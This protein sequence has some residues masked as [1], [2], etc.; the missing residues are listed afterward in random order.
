AQAEVVAGAHRDAVADQVREA[1]DESDSR[2][3]RGALRSGEDRHG[4]D[5]A[6]ERAV[7]HVA[8]VM[9]EAAAGAA[10]ARLPTSLRSSRTVTGIRASRK[11]NAR[12]S[13]GRSWM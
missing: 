3:Q 11:G 7:D 2:A 5:D 8:Q 6:V 10:H 4:G 13:S 9:T 1:Q 12:V